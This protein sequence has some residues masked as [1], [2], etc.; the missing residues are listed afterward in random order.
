MNSKNV[1]DRRSLIAGSVAA[2]A[3]VPLIAACGDDESQARPPNSPDVGDIPSAR[4]VRT[5]GATGDGTT[6]DTDAFAAACADAGDQ[7][8]L[9]IPAGTYKIS[10]FPEVPNFST[11]RGD[12]A[13][14]STLQYEGNGTL[15]QLKARQR[16][17]FQRMGVFC[18]VDGSTAVSIDGCFRCSFD[19]VVLRGQRTAQNHPAYDKQQGV[20]LQGNSGGTTFNN[21]DIN[22]FGTG[23]ITR[24]IQNYITASK[25]TTNRVGVRGAGSDGNA[26]LSMVNVEFVSDNTASSPV[27]HI[28][29][30]GASNDWWL[31]N[32]WL[33]GSDVGISVGGS[34][35]GPS[36]LGITNVKLAASSVGIDLRWCRQPYLANIIFDADPGSSPILLRIDP[37]N[38]R[39]GTAINL[40]SGLGYE[41]PGDTFPSAWNVIGRATQSGPTFISPVVMQ[42]QNNVDDM[43]SFKGDQDRTLSRVGAD[44]A[45]VSEE[46]AGGMVLKG[47]GGS[48]FRLVVNRS[49]QLEARNIG[50]TPPR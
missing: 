26:G 10:Y 18:T 4:N 14:L 28:D 5:F 44:G 27:T 15:I 31:T 3:V 35:G 34:S 42:R 21:C 36:Q 1:F 16:V 19:S 8:V 7:L 13:D 29:I 20:V 11:I 46:P 39:E 41:L 38:S 12:G 37:K 25:F 48:Y 17:S 43:L 30:E 47:E 49:G 9:Y 40:I 50:S 22:N 33:E 2:A 45:W 32:V 24:C 23:L 6:D